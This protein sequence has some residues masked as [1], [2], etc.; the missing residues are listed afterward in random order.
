MAEEWAKIDSK[1]GYY[2]AV[3]AGLCF[4][5]AK[6]QGTYDWYALLVF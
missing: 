6:E 1:G 3:I 5:K 2:N 4:Y